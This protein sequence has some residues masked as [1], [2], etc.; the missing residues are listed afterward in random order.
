M[1]NDGMSAINLVNG[2]RYASLQI[3]FMPHIR[4]HGKI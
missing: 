4:Q 2:L 1:K 3:A